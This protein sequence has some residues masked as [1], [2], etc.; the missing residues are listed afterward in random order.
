[1]VPCQCQAKNDLG[2]ESVQRRA[3]RWILR[4]IIGEISYKQRLQTLALLPLT[5]DRKLRDLVFLYNC[6]FGYTD[7]NIGRCVTFISRAIRNKWALV[8]FSKTNNIARTR[9]AS[10]IWG[11]WKSHKCLFI[12][13]CTRKIL[14]LLINNIDEKIR[15][16][17]I[18][19][20]KQHKLITC[21]YNFFTPFKNRFRLKQQFSQCKVQTI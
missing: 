13:N 8:N 18:I 20:Q 16:A 2:T 9:R 19:L 10:T 1:M 5:Y 12:P 4:T 15:D 11:L 6:I 14:W 17:I 21:K 7:L 3:T